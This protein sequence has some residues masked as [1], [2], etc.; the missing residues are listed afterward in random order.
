MAADP[1]MSAFAELLFLTI[2]DGHMRTAIC[3]ALARIA[4]SQTLTNPVVYVQAA[5]L[6]ALA[7]YNAEQLP[8]IGKPVASIPYGWQVCIL[9]L[10]A[11]MCL[12]CLESPTIDTLRGVLP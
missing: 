11:T 6:G 1:P 12:L 8:E 7:A 10:V 2:S 3:V 5:A 4:L 9:R